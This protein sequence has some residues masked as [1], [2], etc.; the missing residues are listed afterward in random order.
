MKRLVVPLTDAV[1][2]KLPVAGGGG[3][4]RI[5]LDE[6]IAGTKH[7]ALLHNEIAPGSRGSE[8]AHEVEQCFYV[9]GGRGVFTIGGVPHE[10]GP[11]VAVYVPAG[12]LHQVQST[13]T[14]PLS[15]VTMYAPAGPERD[16][17]ARGSQA[18]G[19]PAAGN[20]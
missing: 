4:Y 8:H 1:T 10:V 2:G 3:T 17:R 20:A 15:Y 5:L 9:T 13:G 6:A 12:V 19:P 14:E 7:F 16:L 11:Q 18:F